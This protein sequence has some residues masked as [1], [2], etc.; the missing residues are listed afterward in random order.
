MAFRFRIRMI[1]I[2]VSGN[3]AHRETMDRERPKRGDGAIGEVDHVRAYHGHP[4]GKDFGP[5]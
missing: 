2:C 5:G 3:L 4:G 1:E